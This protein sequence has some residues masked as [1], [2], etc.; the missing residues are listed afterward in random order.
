MALFRMGQCARRNHQDEKSGN[1]LGAPTPSSAHSFLLEET[2]RLRDGVEVQQGVSSDRA[3][4][5][6]WRRPSPL[7]GRQGAGRGVQDVH[8]SG[9]TRAAQ[10]YLV[11]NGAKSSRASNDL[12]HPW[13]QFGCSGWCAC[14]G[15]TSRPP[16]AQLE[17]LLIVRDNV[18]RV[19]GGIAKYQRAIFPLK[20]SKTNICSNSCSNKWTCPFI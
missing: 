7:D 11:C 20:I 14:A 1:Q 12:G 17:G 2:G 19:S 4:N 18:A 6:G 15:S 9:G 8:R 3:A 13:A 10:F 16:G 5:D